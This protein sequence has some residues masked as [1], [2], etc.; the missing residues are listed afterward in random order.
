MGLPIWETFIYDSCG[1]IWGTPISRSTHICSTHIL[2]CTTTKLALNSM[3]LFLGLKAH[4]HGGTCHP[5]IMG[6]LGAG[7]GNLRER[8]STLRE[9]SREHQSN[10]ATTWVQLISTR[11]WTLCWSEPLSP[12][13][14]W[15]RAQWP[16][17]L[18]GW[19]VLSGY[20]GTSNR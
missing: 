19:G 6:C 12:S 8:S 11:I 2:I 5:E 15:N 17:F 20:L 10:L 1:M 3:V 4:S 13:C 9:H 18:L 7:W 16:V 14:P